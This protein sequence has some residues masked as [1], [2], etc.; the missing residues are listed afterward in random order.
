MVDRVTPGVVLISTPDGTGSGF[1]IA[2]D[3]RIVTNEHVVDAHKRVTVIIPGK[4]RHEGRVLG[5]DAIADLAIIDIE[6]SGFTVLDM[7]NSDDISIGEDV[8]AIGYPSS[9]VLGSDPTITRG[10]VSSVREIE[11][12]GGVEHI[13]T[14][15]AINPGNSGGPL[16]NSAGEVIGVNTFLIRETEGIKFA[17]SINE[18]K[19]RLVSLSAGESVVGTTPTPMPRA[20]AVPQPRVSSGS[21][22]LESAELRHDDDES[23][24]SITAFTNVRNFDI[25]ANFHV[26]YSSSVGDWSVGFSFR[27]ESNGNAS[28]VVITNDGEYFH[29]ERN[30]GET[31]IVDEALVTDWNADIGEQNNVSLTVI[32]SRGWLFIN[33]ALFADL[34]LSGSSARGRLEAITGFFEG[35]EVIGRS[36]K[37]DYLI[38]DAIEK[39]HGPSSGSLTKDSTNIAA[40]R[41]NVDAS[42]AYASAEFRT[43]D[44]VENWSAGLMFRKVGREDYLVFYVDSRG[45]WRVSH[46]AVS[47]GDWQTLEEGYS[48]GIDVNAPILNQLEVFYI[49][50][51]ASVYA[52][53]EWL[54]DVDISAE[55]VPESG[56]VIAAYGIYASDDYGAAR[57]DN[58]VVYGLPPN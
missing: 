40:R 47:G 28:F 39:L 13:Q 8:V 19:K 54:S 43:P 27:R 58:F 48:S 22:Y 1:I 7:G 46:A 6:G 10:V 21:F 9:W 17:V 20:T 33:R 42:F 31:T 52:N 34:D 18:V 45:F 57:Y 29:Y 23:I 36:T 37:I 3:G 15:A 2:S 25:G 14:D 50:S 16:F 30:G 24:E 56:D 41:A 44:R 32:E 38:A 26:P 4:G 11:W 49:G 51:V 53:G 55:S 5:V 35:D 12:R